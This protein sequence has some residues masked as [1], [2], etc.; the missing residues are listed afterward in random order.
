MVVE[1]LMQVKD[2]CGMPL[3]RRQRD[4]AGL[5]DLR[6][7]APACALDRIGIKDGAAAVAAAHADST[8][9]AH[10][11]PQELSLRGAV[12]AATGRLLRDVPDLAAAEVRILCCCAG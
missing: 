11:V 9:H 7:N 1:R 8:V 3:A 6:E 10:V 5:A 2:A 4:A 12:A